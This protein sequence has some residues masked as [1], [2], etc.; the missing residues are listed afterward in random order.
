MRP[1][2]NNSQIRAD[3]L[4]ERLITFAVRIIKLTAEL[5]KTPA[6]KH[7]V[8]RLTAFYES[9]PLERTTDENG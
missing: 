6:G 2:E 9:Q 4:E 8:R 1:V 7:I 3:E 5:P